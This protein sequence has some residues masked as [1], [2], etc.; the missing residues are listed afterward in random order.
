MV[1]KRWFCA[2]IKDEN[3]HCLPTLELNMKLLRQTLTTIYLQ[4]F[5]CYSL[6]AKPNVAVV[7]C[8]CIDNVTFSRFPQIVFN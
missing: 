3:Y 7:C 5:Y 6:S 4:Q 1:L 2:K 8:H